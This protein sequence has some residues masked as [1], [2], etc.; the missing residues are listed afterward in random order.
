ML[1]ESVGSFIQGT[2]GLLVV[3]VISTIITFT[4]ETPR[5]VISFK[6]IALIAISFHLLHLG[7]ETVYG[8]HRLFPE[9]LGLAV[10]PLWLFLSFNLMWVGVWLVGLFV[11]PPNRFTIT[12]FWFLAL[13]S[14]V[15]AFAHPTISILVVGYFPGLISSPFVGVLGILLIRQLN[16]ASNNDKLS[17]A[18]A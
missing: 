11:V 9:L 3:L 13:A 2:L 17:E 14:T 16:R 12:T 10:W 8:F 15:N 5:S 7:E 1:G 4:R 6:S 18:G